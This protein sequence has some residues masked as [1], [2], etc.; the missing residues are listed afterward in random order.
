MSIWSL[1]AEVDPFGIGSLD[2][3]KLVAYYAIQ[4][5]KGWVRIKEA[6]MI[7]PDGRNL[8]D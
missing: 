5:N 8:K 1:S 3:L 6:Y 4:R 2:S 7:D